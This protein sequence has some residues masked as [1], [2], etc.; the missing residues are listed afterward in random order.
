MRCAICKITM[1][2]KRAHCYIS[3]TTR[4]ELHRRKYWHRECGE[5]EP[6]KLEALHREVAELD[7]YGRES[8]ESN[9]GSS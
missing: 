3:Y 1:N 9:N 8:E 5:T 4:N 7:H 2:P 6:D